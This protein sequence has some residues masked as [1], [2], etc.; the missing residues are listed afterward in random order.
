M[1]VKYPAKHIRWRIRFGVLFFVLLAELP[2]GYAQIRVDR[3]LDQGRIEIQSQKYAQAVQT[4]SRVI[5]QDPENFEGWYLRGL[6]K[7]YLQDNSGA[8]RDLSRA[9]NLNPSVSGCYLLRGIIRDMNG[10]YYK[11]L[12]D[13]TAGLAIEPN[14]ANLYYSRGTTRLRLNNFSSAILDFNEA[15]RIHPRM[16]EA[17]VNRGLAKA[18][19]LN[20]EGAFSDFN[21]A[22]LLNPFSPDGHSRKGLLLYETK[23]YQEALI[24]FGEAI[25]REDSNPQNYY[26]RALTWYEMGYKDSCINDLNRVIAL[27]PNHSLSWYN[28]AIIKAQMQDFKGAIQDYEK[29][30]Q[31]QP[32]HVLS[33]FNRGLLREEIGDHY[34]ALYDLDQAV[35]IYPDFAKAYLARAQIKGKLGDQLGAQTDRLLAQEK[36]QANQG[37]TE[38]SLAQNYADTT[39]RFEDLITLNSVFNASFNQRYEEELS[40]GEL[41][42]PVRILDGNLLPTDASYMLKQNSEPLLTFFRQDTLIASACLKGKDSLYNPGIQILNEVLWENK[43]NLAALFVRAGL[44]F[45]M[46]EFIRSTSLLN[47]RVPMQMFG[48]PVKGPMRMADQV[49]YSQVLEDYSEIIRL[50]PDLAVVWMNRGLVRI[51]ARDFEGALADFRKAIDL[52][53]D[54]ADAWFNLGVT[55]IKTGHKEEGCMSLSKAGEYG[56]ERAYRSITI[57]CSSTE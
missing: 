27:D 39:V 3:F 34:G 43:N 40:I 44:R 21:E 42:G 14:D 54:Y 24:S 52:V 6:S 31:L 16:D 57:H 8:L 37:Q 4:L 46:I 47:D 30:N 48:D 28:R 45:D 9:I 13:F 19:L 11:A 15:I 5:L 36:I 51:H 17:Y 32:Y 53:P 7:F 49:D 2:G 10:D 18:R 20:R 33:Y 23:K 50:D 41:M 29:V 1:E 12:E 26:M 25:R 35:L 55:L 38:E 56:L 22:I